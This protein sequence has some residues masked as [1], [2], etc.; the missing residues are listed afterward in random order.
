M[1]PHTDHRYRRMLAVPLFLAIYGGAAFAQDRSIAV[2]LGENLGPNPLEF[3]GTIAARVNVKDLGLPLSQAN[4]ECR[5][6]ALLGVPRVAQV[7]LTIPKAKRITIVAVDENGQFDAGIYVVREDRSAHFCADSVHRPVTM[8][9]SAGRWLVFYGPRSQTGAYSFRLRDEGRGIVRPDP[10]LGT[11]TF[12][13]QPSLIPNPLVLRLALTRPA[14]LRPES[15]FDNSCTRFAQLDDTPSFVLEVTGTPRTAPFHLHASFSFAIFDPTTG[16]WQCIR[17]DGDVTLKPGRHAVHVVW[18]AGAD[19]FNHPDA[20]IA[21]SDTGKPARLLVDVT[22]ANVRELPARLDKPV[23]LRGSTAGPREKPLIARADCGLRPARPDFYLRTPVQDAIVQLFGGAHEIELIGPIDDDG[24]FQTTAG[25]H[26]LRNGGPKPLHLEGL[27]AAYVAGPA[28]RETVDYALRIRTEHSAAEPVARVAEPPGDL[29]LDDRNLAR[30]YPDF[31][32]DWRTTAD[33]YGL[34]HRLWMDVPKNLIVFPRAGVRNAPPPGT[35]MLVLERTFDATNVSALLPDGTLWSTF[36]G[37]LELVPKAA[38]HLPHA[39]KETALE[40]AHFAGFLDAK[41]KAAFD[42]RVREFDDCVDKVLAQLDPD[43]KA[44]RYDVVTYHG[45][46]VSRVEALADRNFR[47]AHQRC[48]GAA[49]DRF[50]QSIVD[51]AISAH[52][53]FVTS[54]LK[55]L[56]PRIRALFPAE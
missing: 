42:R 39:T 23:V 14:S 30:W 28:G 41:D 27:Y 52:L 55:Q 9:L 35:P 50:V 17:S 8:N 43:G 48:N 56:E 33:W 34:V 53:R 21:I 36:T 12:A 16:R 5:T 26:C 24:T 4:E 7:S 47:T 31:P 19:R 51:K 37:E 3:R 46:K 6:I 15:A 29:A 45:G 32:R 44:G 1:L 13:L 22:A 2:T 54:N 49:T 18:A 20:W 11:P 10:P 25:T 38:V 40:K